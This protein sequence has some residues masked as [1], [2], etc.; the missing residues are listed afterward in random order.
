M[1]QPET[2]GQIGVLELRSNGFL[3][4]LLNFFADLRILGASGRRLTSEE[5]FGSVLFGECIARI[6][7][8]GVTRTLSLAEWRAG[9]VDHAV[10]ISKQVFLRFNWDSP[11]VA[12][13]A[14]IAKNLLER[15]L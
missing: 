4:K 10:E 12:Q 1:F 8:V 6:P 15:R 9:I 7:E 14:R 13:A 3:Q 5:T 2:R 11:D